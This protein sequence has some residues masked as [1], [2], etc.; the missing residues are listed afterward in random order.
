[1]TIE[2]RLAHANDA[3]GI[4]AIY[5]PYCETTRVSFEVVAPTVDQMRERIARIGATYPWVV[6]EN[7]GRLL[8]YVYASQFRER[9]AYRWSVEVAV[10]VAMTEQRR[11]VG[12]ALYTTLF[13]IL[14]S[15]GYS[16]AI[17]GIT[18]PNSASVGLHESVGF[19][20]A[21]CFAGVG[22]KA[23]KW[24][25]VGWW[26]LELQPEVDNPREPTPIGELLHSAGL[27]TAFDEGM[28]LIRG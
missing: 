9:A 2:I 8:G 7:H 19:R 3:A 16:K 24:L 28:Q 13:S 25:D 12:R 23:D 11:G 22:F 27:S 26:Q 17:A 6:A 21:G 18:L 20:P 15:Q 10:Y 4:R 1:M 5:A 14:R